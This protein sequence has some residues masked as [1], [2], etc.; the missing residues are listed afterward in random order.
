MTNVL[1]TGAGGPAGVAVIVDLVEDGNRVLGVDADPLSAG[2]ALASA[3]AL[4]PR[5]D[6]P[7]FG[8]AIRSLV[9]DHAIEARTPASSLSRGAS[10]AS[11]E[12][13]W[14]LRRS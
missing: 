10:T 1:V 4:I 7:A 12:A 6:D 14:V 3:S 8:Y 2:F 11:I 5:A 9:I 13:C